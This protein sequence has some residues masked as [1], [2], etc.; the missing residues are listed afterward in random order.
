MNVIMLSFIV[1]NQFGTQQITLMV[2]IIRQRTIYDRRTTFNFVLLF[3]VI[4]LCLLS[5]DEKRL[6]ML[7]SYIGSV[8]T[9]ECVDSNSLLQ[10]IGPI[11]MSAVTRTRHCCVWAPTDSCNTLK[12]VCEASHLPCGVTACVTAW[13]WRLGSY[14]VTD[15]SKWH[16][17]TYLHIERASVLDERVSQLVYLVSY[18]VLSNFY[19]R[20]SLY[21]AS[22]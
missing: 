17:F 9:V 22:K 11:Y 15:G 3:T 20:T 6:F 8:L 14:E 12:A 18:I 16:R 10:W 4:C 7:I 1:L 5:T 13:R 19:V 2:Y 21:H